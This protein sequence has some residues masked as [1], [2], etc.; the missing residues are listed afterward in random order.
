MDLTTL[1]EIQFA[2]AYKNVCD[3]GSIYDMDIAHVLYQN[4]RLIA[5]ITAEN[6]AHEEA[7]AKAKSRR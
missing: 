3:S 5:Q 6:K 2:L 7:V 1:R 4:E